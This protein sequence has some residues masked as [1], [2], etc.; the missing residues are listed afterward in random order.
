MYRKTDQMTENLR[1]AIVLSERYICFPSAH[2]QNSAAAD[3]SRV[4]VLTQRTEVLS[5]RLLV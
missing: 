4:F 2:D 5:G 1:A 3:I